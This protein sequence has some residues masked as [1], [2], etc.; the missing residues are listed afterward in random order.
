MNYTFP[1]NF[2]W[3][4][5]SS[6]PQS[7]GTSPGDGKA[8]NQWD[9]WYAQAPEKF[10]DHIGPTIT[11][12][13]YNNY[14]EIIRAMAD[15]G[16]K[17]YRTSLQWSRIL[18]DKVGTINQT[19]INFYHAV[20]DEL[21]KYNII[22]MFC[23]HHFDTP[24]YHMA[25]GGFENR[26]TVTAFA[27]YV[28]ICFSHFGD[29]VKY[30]STFNEPVVIPHQSYILGG[31][32]P[33]LCDMKKAVQ[34]AYHLQLASALAIAAFREKKIDGQIGIILNLTPT[35]MENPKDPA[36]M[37]AA[38]ICDLLHNRSFLDPSV[39]GKYPP[40][41]CDFLEAEGLSPLTCERDLA[42]IEKNTVDYLGVNYYHPRRVRPKKQ[43]PDA[44]LTP[45]SFYE[46][47][48][49]KDA[50]F[51]FSRGWEIYA[52]AVYDIAI[53]IRD[54][55]KN[56]PWYMSENGMGVMEEEQFFDEKGIVQDDYRIAFLKE[57]LT[58][59]HKGIS[60]GSNC[61]GYHLWAPF[62]CWS[63]TNAYKNRYGL[64]RVDIYDDCKISLKKSASWYHSL[65]AE[66]GF[67]TE[68]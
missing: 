48:V 37:R 24:M 9:Y 1:D 47:Y 19:G 25:A 26:E 65:S 62:D 59:L 7:E 6:G 44:P 27:E 42:A 61:F 52:P 21:E 28:K 60:A 15:A 20:L 41:L 53:N 36:N 3:G 5:A 33:A 57:H 68:K 46:E 34:V 55:Y 66:N 10:Y 18:K 40:A 14:K 22:P 58:E 12:N 45:E 64:I 2:L 63:W 39:L 51:N 32:Y 35:Y 50:Q 56:I 30:W 38:E 43:I 13:F 54:N 29:R 17:S 49:P 23:L 8:E 31:H 4:G 16:I 11:S 67:S